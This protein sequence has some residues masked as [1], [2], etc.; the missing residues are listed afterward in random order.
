[1]SNL[2]QKDALFLKQFS[3]AGPWDFFGQG[4]CESSAGPRACLP[5]EC[6]SGITTGGRTMHCGACPGQNVTSVNLCVQNRCVPPPTL[7]PLSVPGV[8][9]A[10]GPVVLR[11]KVGR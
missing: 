4:R 5:N 10:D 6:G 2:E 3:T 8:I 1:M 7:P 9:D 11:V